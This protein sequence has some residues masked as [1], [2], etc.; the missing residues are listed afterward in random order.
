MLGFISGFPSEWDP[1]YNFHWWGY[2]TGTP[3][4][5]DYAI[6][7]NSGDKIYTNND[8]S[9]DTYLSAMEYYRNYVNTH[10]INT[11]IIYTTG[12]VQ[13][14]NPAENSYQ[15][16]VKMDY[17]REFVKED[18]TRI[19]FDWADILAYDNN[20][21]QSTGTYNGHTY[22]YMTPTNVGD[23]SIGHISPTGAIRLAKA[24]WWMLA[25]IAGWDGVSTTCP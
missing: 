2:A 14:S 1:E 7:L 21:A 23:G 11:E 13:A 17:I 9:I 18:P 25:R 6:G 4:N 5:D 22:Q 20:G 16:Q 3:D 10:G 24:Q 19:L 12:P 8:V 15:A